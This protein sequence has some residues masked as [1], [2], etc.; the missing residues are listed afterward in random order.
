MIAN[1]D[2]SCNVNKRENVVQLKLNNFFIKNDL[3]ETDKEDLTRQKSEDLIPDET[4][5]AML[6]IKDLI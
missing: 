4:P 5:K 2:N 3:D 6:D 1:N